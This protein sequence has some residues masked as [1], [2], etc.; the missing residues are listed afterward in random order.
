M[1][2]ALAEY[3]FQQAQCTYMI[4]VQI[5][6][7]DRHSEFLPGQEDR[8]TL[9]IEDQVAQELLTLFDGVLIDEVKITDV[10]QTGSVQVMRMLHL[11]V[12]CPHHAFPSN[13]DAVEMIEYI[14][15]QQLARAL[16]ELFEMLEVERFEVLFMPTAYE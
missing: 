15:E 4:Y 11:N 13:P 6:Y 12:R 1:S 10:V 9:L 16:L 14:V 5:G 3:T 7:P 8:T 2:N